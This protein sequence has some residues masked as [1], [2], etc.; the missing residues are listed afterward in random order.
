MYHS[1]HQPVSRA[2]DFGQGAIQRAAQRG[3]HFDPDL[4]DLFLE[5]MP[6]VLV[7]KERYADTD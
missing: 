4:L 1:V 3:K 5:S 7:I 6:H 2:S